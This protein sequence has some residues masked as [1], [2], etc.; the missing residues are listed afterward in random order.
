MAAED[1]VQILH[2]HLSEV[3]FLNACLQE[4][5]EHHLSIADQGDGRGGPS[6]SASGNMSLSE[7]L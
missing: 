3:L 4:K 2:W 7:D 6:P 1:E 5:L